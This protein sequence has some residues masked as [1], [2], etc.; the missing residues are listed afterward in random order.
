MSSRWSLACKNAMFRPSA[1]CL[2]HQ[3]LLRGA[4]L[5]IVLGAAE[6]HFSYLLLFAENLDD[7]NGVHG[8]ALC[9]KGHDTGQMS[10]S[11]RH[12]ISP[13]SNIHVLHFH[14]KSNAQECS[15]SRDGA[16]A[17]LSSAD[18]VLPVCPGSH[19]LLVQILR[20]GLPG[21]EVACKG[22]EGVAVVAPVLHELRRQL[23]LHNCGSIREKL[24]WLSDV[25]MPSKD[26]W[27]FV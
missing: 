22:V 18:T 12:R 25:S 6:Q 5:Q 9:L 20:Q 23:H 10:F 16:S 3:L 19:K 13:R 26:I 21:L 1:G 11:L 4:A 15:I 14:A 8:L 27:L 2:W 24:Q 17:F 7:R